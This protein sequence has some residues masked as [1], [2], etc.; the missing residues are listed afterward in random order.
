MRLLLQQYE[1]VGCYVNV[2][3]HKYYLETLSNNF[4]GF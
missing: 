1:Y 2:F 3:S 4:S